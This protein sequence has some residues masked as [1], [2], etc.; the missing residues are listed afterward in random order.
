MKKLFVLLL[1]FWALSSCDRG[2]DETAR[3]ESTPAQRPE[4]VAAVAEGE[5]SEFDK[6]ANGFIRP[7]FDVEGTQTEKTVK[8]GEN[9]DLYI[10]A[11][12][13]KDFAMCAAE[14][15]LVVPDG[16]RVL[17]SANTDSTILTLGD[18]E[19]FSTTFRCTAGP[20]MWL[21]RYTCTSDPTFRGGEIR[22]EK[23]A[24]M[25]FLGFSLC[26]GEFTLVNARPGTATLS[27]E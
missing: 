16:M 23:G 5:F 18:L 21:V 6:L 7:Y 11:E 4:P 24:N 1:A 2:G 9:F 10:V 22:T 20:K 19:D 3:T 26:D 13:N 8:A 17:S 25:H 12:Y 15:R 27:V 14:Y